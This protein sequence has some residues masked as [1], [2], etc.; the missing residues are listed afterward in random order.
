MLLYKNYN[1]HLQQISIFT[2]ILSNQQEDDLNWKHRGFEL[3]AYVFAD[4]Y[5]K[6]QK[7]LDSNDDDDVLMKTRWCTL[8][9][10]G[11]EALMHHYPFSAEMR[12]HLTLC[13]FIHNPPTLQNTRM[14]EQG[15]TDWMRPRMW[16]LM[17][18]SGY[19]YSWGIICSLTCIMLTARIIMAVTHQQRHT[20][21]F[22]A[23]SLYWACLT[24]MFS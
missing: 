10:E 2:T 7:M 20:W 15:V 8:R 1:F 21:T 6:S 5:H 9:Q 17:A 12:Q 3:L 13:Q 16:T 23:R 22:T 19:Y 18:L 11:V 14:V 4:S 24:H